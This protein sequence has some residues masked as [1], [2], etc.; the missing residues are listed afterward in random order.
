MKRLSSVLA[1]VL[2]GTTANVFASRQSVLSPNPDSS[3]PIMLEEDFDEALDQF[4]A[5]SEWGEVDP[6][7][8]VHHSKAASHIKEGAKATEKRPGPH[9]KEVHASPFEEYSSHNP[10]N[11]YG[12]ADTLKEPVVVA[13]KP[14]TTHTAG[15]KARHTNSTVPL[16]P[17]SCSGNGYCGGSKCFCK[18]G[19]SG[20]DCSVPT[21]PNECNGNGH[22]I[23]GQCRCFA[24]FNGFDCSFRG[25]LDQCNHRGYCHI[26]P[27]RS[28]CI[29]YPGFNGTTCKEGPACGYGESGPSCSGNGLCK[30]QKCY[31]KDGFTGEDCSQ[32]VCPVG[33]E[34]KTMCSGHGVCNTKT[35]TCECE[36]PHF[37]ANC[38]YAKCPN[39]CSKNGFCGKDGKCQ[40]KPGFFGKD[41]SPQ[42][43]PEDC[44]HHG[45]CVFKSHS[46][47]AAPTAKCICNKGYGPGPNDKHNTCSHRICQPGFSGPDC[48]KKQC[49]DNC[50][51]NLG[52]GKCDQ[53]TFTCVCKDGWSGVSCQLKSCPNLCNHHGTCVN[54]VCNCKDE[55]SGLACDVPPL[56][57]PKSCSGHG[58]CVKGQCFCQDGWSGKACEKHSNV[59]KF[60]KKP[61]TPYLGIVCIPACSENGV[62]QTTGPPGSRTNECFCK[63]GWSGLS[64]DT[65]VHTPGN[66][67]SLDHGASVGPA[68]IEQEGRSTIAARLSRKTKSQS[69]LR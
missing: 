37:G 63:D 22:C 39:D 7:K 62:C 57:C 58:S 28:V 35:G 60:V 19:F 25:C 41:C 46:N 31:C 13:H 69:T 2:L 38:A 49:I 53:K 48:K 12:P 51:S 8:V 15:K 50:N 20:P 65:Y 14:V 33:G 6:H 16:C 59:S 40:C 30:D 52:H 23:N 17:S 61:Q 10:Y 34:H 26:G 4:S 64:C 56:K 5:L 68:F 43:C 32:K 67:R 66:Y 29:C 9:I 21:C 24:G 11:P 27:D 18:E 55:W 47:G 45:K 1:V 3:A 54:G 36:H 42:N 44:N